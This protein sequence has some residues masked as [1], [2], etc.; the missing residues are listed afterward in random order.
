MSFII[1]RGNNMSKLNTQSWLPDWR[2]PEAYPKPDKT[3]LHQWAWEFL[4]RNEFYQAS[5]SALS[6]LPP[7]GDI[8]AFKRNL[9][10]AFSLPHLDSSYSKEIIK[11]LVRCKR[12]DFIHRYWLDTFS[13]RLD[14]A[15][16][17][18]PQFKVPNY[19]FCI[20]GELLRGTPPIEIPHSFGYPYENVYTFSL[21]ENINKQIKNLKLMIKSEK[22]DFDCSA[23]VKKLKNECLPE[24][25]EK[26]ILY[27]RILDAAASGIPVYMLDKCVDILDVI[28]NDKR[29][30]HK[31]YDTA[32]HLT[33]SGY[34][35][36]LKSVNPALHSHTN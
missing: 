25:Q 29:A 10:Q 26:Y 31:I 20:T 36:I 18:H 32:I 4:R 30:F 11:D 14:P 27:L 28:S 12:Y 5:Y 15:S 34:R 16:K 7:V 24:L 13:R 22:Q 6:K 9:Q 35:L 17:C 23:D 8:K 21:A 2:D 19:P 1:Q 3:S 33:D